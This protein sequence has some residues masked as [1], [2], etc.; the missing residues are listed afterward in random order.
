MSFLRHD[1]SRLTTAL[2][3]ALAVLF[4]ST[5]SMACE[6]PI[7]QDMASMSM[8]GDSGPCEHKTVTISCQKACLV[9]CQGLIPQGGGL[10]PARLYESVRYPSLDARHADFTAEADDP[11][12]RA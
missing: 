3:A 7:E 1:L 6:V 10:T 4:V 2:L 11:P 8:N 12:P 9:F 5:A